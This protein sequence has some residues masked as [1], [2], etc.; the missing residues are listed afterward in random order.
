MEKGQEKSAIAFLT[1][2]I[3]PFFR[4][5]SRRKS[6]YHRRRK[7]EIRKGGREG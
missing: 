1:R 5:N 7:K 4:V 6:K 2:S 3:Y